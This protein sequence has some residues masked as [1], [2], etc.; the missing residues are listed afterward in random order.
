MHA[1]ERILTS[2]EDLVAATADASVQ[3]ITVLGT[4]PDAP[5]MRPVAASARRWSRA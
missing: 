1:P 2:V 3:N 4:I 5:S